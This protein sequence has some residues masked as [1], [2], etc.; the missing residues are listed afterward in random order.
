MLLYENLARARMR[1]AEQ[2]ARRL[3]LV[4]RLTMAKRWNRVSRW[5]ARHCTDADQ[6]LTHSH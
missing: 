2:A 4:R 6:S 1:E 3:R 5:A